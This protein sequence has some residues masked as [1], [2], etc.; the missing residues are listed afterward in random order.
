MQFA[1]LQ[2]GRPSQHS[3]TLDRLKVA[4]RTKGALGK[5]R[6]AAMKEEDTLPPAE[7][8]G[9]GAGVPVEFPN[10]R[11]GESVGEDGARGVT[12]LRGTADQAAS[13]A[14]GP[15]ARGRGRGRGRVKPRVV[16]RKK[17]PTRIVVAPARTSSGSHGR[18][19]S[20]AG[21]TR[22]GPVRG[23]D[24]G[25]G[26]DRSSGRDHGGEHSASVIGLGQIAPQRVP[27]SSVS[28]GSAAG[29]AA[30]RKS[31]FAASQSSVGGQGSLASGQSLGSTGTG[32]IGELSSLAG[33]HSER[34]PYEAGTRNGVAANEITHGGAMLRSLNESLGDNSDTD[35]ELPYDDFEHK[36]QDV[37]SFVGKVSSGML[38]PV[39]LP[40]LRHLECPPKLFS[41]AD[42]ECRPGGLGL[43]TSAGVVTKVE[44]A[45]AGDPRYSSKVREQLGAIVN[46]SESRLTA[47]MEPVEL[48]PVEALLDDYRPGNI[49]KVYVPDVGKP[50]D[51]TQFPPGTSVRHV[52]CAEKAPIFL[53]LPGLLPLKE[54][55]AAWEKSDMQVASSAKDG[56]RDS[57]GASSSSVFA[58]MRGL[59]TDIRRVGVPGEVERIG[60]LRLYRSGKV[61]L[62]FRDGTTYGVTAG[63][64][65][66]TNQQLVVLKVGDTD[67]EKS[68]EEL[69][70]ALTSRLVCAPSLESLVSNSRSVAKKVPSRS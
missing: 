7:L 30:S 42:E 45:R 2:R 29:S 61:E 32:G 67:T 19:G 14:D 17:P 21:S 40:S 22:G 6:R 62:V 4:L 63:A 24:G 43:T 28:Q 8:S 60:K 53:Q 10:R 5:L 20:G 26:R 51:V 56:I 39:S 27:A 3:L 12:E 11:E 46:M 13:T 48:E 35:D 50:I 59:G 70:N 64:S 44:D 47:K 55:P 1:G 16:P 68:C 38:L 65:C 52:L 33:P 9:A 54:H 58:D 41:K 18:G 69:A 23:R 25:S 36:N 49:E 37:A 66:K 31:S 34:G 15:A 57:A